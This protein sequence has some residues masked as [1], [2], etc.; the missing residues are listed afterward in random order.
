M[1]FEEGSDDERDK[2]EEYGQVEECVEE[3]N[4][5]SNSVMGM[6]SPRT[7]KLEGEIRGRRV[8]TLIDS[9]AT[10]NFISERLV[11]DLEIPVHKARYTVVLGDDRK[12]TGIGRCEGIQLMVS[13]LTIRQDFLPFSLG[14]VDIILGMEWLKSLGEVK[15]NR[16]NQTMKFK[17]EGRKVELK[18]QTSLRKVETTLKTLFKLIRKKGKLSEWN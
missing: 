1:I 10:Y 5:N 4:L 18:R 13:E 14:G 17:W 12:V 11:A 6:D 2:T 16:G 3:A 9:G 7:M 15:I 8:V